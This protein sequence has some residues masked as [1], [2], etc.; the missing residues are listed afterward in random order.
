MSVLLAFIFRIL[1][2]TSAHLLGNHNNSGC[3]R[4]SPDSRNGEELPES[5]KEVVGLGQTGFLNQKL[6]KIQLGMD[7]VQIASRLKRNTSQSK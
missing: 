3:L 5:S 4:C 2:L 7:I 1:L 6:L